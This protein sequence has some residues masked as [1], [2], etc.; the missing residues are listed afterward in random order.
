MAAYAGSAARGYRRRGQ[1]LGLSLEP[2]P[3]SPTSCPTAPYAAAATAAV[4]VAPTGPEPEWW[5][6]E[7]RSKEMMPEA[8]LTAKNSDEE[9]GE[10]EEE[11]EEAPRRRQAFSTDTFISLDTE[12]KAAEPAPA[13]AS[14]SAT[15]SHAASLEVKRIQH[16]AGRLFASNARVGTEEL[17]VKPNQI[18]ALTHGRLERA[19]DR[20]RA[21]SELDRRFRLASMPGSVRPLVTAAAQAPLYAGERLMTHGEYVTDDAAPLE[22][23]L[24][25]PN[26]SAAA[27]LVSSRDALFMTG[28]SAA[29]GYLESLSEIVRRNGLPPVGQLTTLEDEPSPLPI[30]A[31]EMLTVTAEIRER[32]VFASATSSAR[33]FTTPLAYEQAKANL[34]RIRAAIGG[35]PGTVSAAIEPLEAALF[36]L[37]TIGH[38]AAGNLVDPPL[39]EEAAAAFRAAPAEAFLA[40]AARMGERPIYARV[41]PSATDE[42]GGEEGTVR[43]LR[44]DLPRLGLRFLEDVY[45]SPVAASIVRAAASA[46]VVL[47]INKLKKL[48]AAAP[49]PR[50]PPSPPAQLAGGFNRDVISKAANSVREAVV[51]GQPL[52]AGKAA[53]MLRNAI[54]KAA[55]GAGATPEARELVCRGAFARVMHSS[56]VA[57]FALASGFFRDAP[58]LS[59]PADVVLAGDWRAA[60][61]AFRAFV[62]GD[63]ELTP[64]AE[65]LSAQRGPTDICVPA[66]G[67]GA[68]YVYVAP[69]LAAGMP[70]DNDCLLAAGARAFLL[71]QQVFAVTRDG[72]DPAHSV[73]RNMRRAATAWLLGGPWLAGRLSAD[74]KMPGVLDVLTTRPPEISN[75]EYVTLLY[76]VQVLD[77]EERE[78]EPPAYDPFLTERA[79]AIV[80]AEA[81]DARA[82]SE[83]IVRLFLSYVSMYAPTGKAENGTGA[84]P[85]LTKT[86]PAAGAAE[87][88]RSGSSLW[89]IMERAAAGEGWEIPIGETAKES[90]PLRAAVA[91]DL[92]AAFLAAS[93]EAWAK[94]PRYRTGSRFTLM[95]AAYDDPAF[96][97][98]GA[99][100]A[101]EHPVLLAEQCHAEALGAAVAAVTEAQ[102][103]RKYLNDF[104]ARHRLELYPID[105]A[106]ARAGAP[107]IVPEYEPL[108][109]VARAAE[110]AA[111]EDR[112]FGKPSA[113]DWINALLPY[114]QGGAMPTSWR[115]LRIIYRLFLGRTLFS[116]AG[117]ALVARAIAATHVPT[118]TPIY[119]LHRTISPEARGT[120]GSPVCSATIETGRVYRGDGSG[121]EDEDE[122][123]VGNACAPPS[124]PE[125]GYA[126]ASPAQRPSPPPPPPSVAAAAKPSSPPPPGRRVSYKITDRGGGASAQAFTFNSTV[127]V[128]TRVFGN[129]HVAASKV[130][131]VGPDALASRNAAPTPAASA[132]S[133]FGSSPQRPPTALLRRYFDAQRAVFAFQKAVRAQELAFFLAA[134][135]KLRAPAGDTT[136]SDGPFG[137]RLRAGDH[138]IVCVEPILVF[139]GPEFA[140]GVPDSTPGGASPATRFRVSFADPAPPRLPFSV[141]EIATAIG[142][143][144]NEP[145]VAPPRTPDERTYR[146]LQGNAR[147]LLSLPGDPFH[148]PAFVCT[149]RSPARRPARRAQPPSQAPPKDPALPR[150]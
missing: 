53:L 41:P 46:A 143:F 115:H 97:L 114:L 5:A 123:G 63:A 62:L 132:G 69:Y 135:E 67:S 136:A 16:V 96:D 131:P 48:A 146:V 99:Q 79:G 144:L 39:A 42:E 124:V 22:T 19:A 13:S 12:R 125:P 133:R 9:T 49:D 61:D 10:G 140:G 28:A 71:V 98:P 44:E 34:A 77:A 38:T 56:F 84:T 32:T 145:G 37:Q 117:N 68:P 51:R 100:W 111:R 45:T 85:S 128:R 119:W 89:S 57:P 52:V 94:E 30:T 122:E 2:P 4:P 20:R 103:D 24:V 102:G 141:P 14:A 3:T 138:P 60:Y 113:A 127:N 8:W 64:L 88:A 50:K 65:L 81:E 86:V 15:D 82:M 17:A 130:L 121:D 120:R 109:V 66:N 74:T 26:L 137:L 104:V 87:A 59:V 148:L 101:I 11:E 134:W 142:V 93:V 21:Y 118:A 107:P 29:P 47:A 139:N 108:R 1:G 106:A 23:A 6:L 150:S 78:R 33:V 75:E 55:G 95:P 18:L 58:H 90:S 126:G 112:R 116:L 129:F 110:E 40:P 31:R 25:A 105:I 43:V 92:P 72:G 83:E 70:I 35:S 27:G 149:V 76:D 91:A 36:D 54:D 7:Q 80:I 147:S 73:S